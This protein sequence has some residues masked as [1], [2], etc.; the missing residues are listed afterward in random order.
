LTKLHAL[1]FYVPWTVS[2]CNEKNWFFALHESEVKRFGH[3]GKVL[4]M[5]ENQDK[6]EPLEKKRNLI[7]GDT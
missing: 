5:L 3:A 2:S 7:Q 4:M 6:K 1:N